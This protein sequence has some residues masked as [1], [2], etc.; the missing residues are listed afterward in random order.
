MEEKDKKQA[1]INIVKNLEELKVLNFYKCYQKKKEIKRKKGF[2]VSEKS[3]QNQCVRA[4]RSVLST[5][6]NAGFCTKIC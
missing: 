6:E 3:C 5:H 2:T 4:R 1:I